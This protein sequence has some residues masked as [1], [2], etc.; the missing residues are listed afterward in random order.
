LTGALVEYGA[1]VRR[2]SRW[3]SSGRHCDLSSPTQ[4]EAPSKR[5]RVTM[6]M[7]SR[8]CSVADIS[9]RASC[10]SEEAYHAMN[11]KQKGSVA[12]EQWIGGDIECRIAAQLLKV[13]V[14]GT[15]GVHGRH[16]KHQRD[17]ALEKAIQSSRQIN[18]PIQRCCS[19]YITRPSH[20]CSLYITLMAFEPRDVPMI[21]VGD[22]QR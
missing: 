10:N 8:H 17:T 14:L 1:R 22:S 16:C 21:D 11:T 7:M 4:L 13:L 15:I 2:T 18:Q 9:R 19:H 3:R 20:V 6:T 5:P 12:K